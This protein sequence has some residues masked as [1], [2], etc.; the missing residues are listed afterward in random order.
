MALEADDV[1]RLRA[2]TGRRAIDPG[3][4]L[5]G[6]RSV[7]WRVN[8][9]M[10]LLLGGGRALLLQV[11]H[12]LVAAGV[13]AHSRFRTEPVARL[14]RTLDRMLTITFGT[15]P[16]ALEAVHD[17]ERVHTR[18]RGALAADVGPY[19]RGTPY[20]AA[21]PDL[22]LWVHATL[23]DTALLVFERFV[24]PLEPRARAAYHEESKTVARV[25]GIPD[26]LIPD[27]RE[28]FEAYV[29]G[30]IASDR[31]AVGDEGRAIAASILH[32]PVARGLAPLLGVGRFLTTGLL[33]PP[34]RDRYGLGW[35]EGRETLLR[36]V[37]A[38]TRRIVPLLPG[39]IRFMPHAR[40]ADA[41]RRRAPARRTRPATAAAHAPG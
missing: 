16:E 27:G 30:M 8:R 28:A 31:L 24:G 19:M 15:A 22:L 37:A 14:R 6:P 38:V 23:V 40:R 3:A 1:E 33:P 7:T 11:A 26:A 2:A 17:I 34:L 29:A 20:D 18:V 35:S 9:E 41:R 13:A 10:A 32:P 25:L 39:P 5:F 12:P 36:V 4:S 21:D